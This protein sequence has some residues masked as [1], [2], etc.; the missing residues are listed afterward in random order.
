MFYSSEII[1]DKLGE[2]GPLD[3][4]LQKTDELFEMSSGLNVM[5]ALAVAETKAYAMFQDYLIELKT[6]G[7]QITL[8][9][10]AEMASKMTIGLFGKVYEQIDPVNLGEISRSMKIAEEYGKRLDNK[11]HNLKSKALDRL[12][13]GYPS[14]DFVIDQQEAAGLFTNVRNPNTDEKIIFDNIENYIKI[15]RKP[16]ESILVDFL[17]TPITVGGKNGK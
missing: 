17:S 11:S 1:I 7:G 16:N 4:Q 15:W 10:A 3:I 13:T 12:I 5:N 9:T 2:L 6:V 14:H 8:K